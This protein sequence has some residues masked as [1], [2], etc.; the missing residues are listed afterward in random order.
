MPRSESANQRNK[1]KLTREQA[2]QRGGQATSR[3]HG[4]TF[5]AEIGRRGG[6][7]VSRNRQHMAEIG[8][9]GGA[10]RGRRRTSQA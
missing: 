5:F 10:A 7:T 3:K 9:R 1:P 2:G 6:Q 4:H 8:R